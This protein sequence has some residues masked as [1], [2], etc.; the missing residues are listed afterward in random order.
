MTLYLLGVYASTWNFMT[1]ARERYIY[2]VSQQS[3]KRGGS[4]VVFTCL[5]FSLFELHLGAV[6]RSGTSSR[7]WPW[8]PKSDLVLDLSGITI[9][10]AADRISDLKVMRVLDAQRDY[11]DNI[12]TL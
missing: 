10:V 9:G 8:V 11:H 7:P 6:T 5:Y 2:T 1:I 3:G 4:S 12:A